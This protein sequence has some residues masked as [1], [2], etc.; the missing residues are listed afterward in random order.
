[1]GKLKDWRT[2]QE[3]KKRWV[4]FTIHILPLPLLA[5]VFWRWALFIWYLSWPAFKFACCPTDMHW[6]WDVQPN[7][8]PPLQYLQPRICLRCHFYWWQ[9]LGKTALFFRALPTHRAERPS[10]S[11][12]KYMVFTY[13]THY[14]Y[15]YNFKYIEIKKCECATDKIHQKIIKC[16]DTTSESL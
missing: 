5:F 9:A 11:C 7:I 14:I 6:I 16:Q 10:I 1:M 12:Y 13:T 4:A 8:W 2:F 15:L 3:A